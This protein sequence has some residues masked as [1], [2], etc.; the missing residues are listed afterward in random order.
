MFFAAP[1]LIPDV[2]AFLLNFSP[3]LRAQC[4]TTTTAVQWVNAYTLADDHDRATIYQLLRWLGVLRT[5][6]MR[7]V[8]ADDAR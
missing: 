1:P 7:A 8:I 6:A 5:V 3:F 2:I 4:P